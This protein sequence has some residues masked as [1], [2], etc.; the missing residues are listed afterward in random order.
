MGE[1]ME[2]LPEIQENVITKTA[3]LESAWENLR[4]EIGKG[5]EDEVNVFLDVLTRGLKLASDMI[6]KHRK[7]VE[8][9]RKEEMS[10]YYRIDR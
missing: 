9:D 3:Q 1:K 2:T 8:K 10:A 6:E 4:I 5:I 7:K